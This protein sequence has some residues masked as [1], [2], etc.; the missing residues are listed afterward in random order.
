VSPSPS[1]LFWNELDQVTR[2]AY[3]FAG[4]VEHWY[5]VAGKFIVLRFA[6]TALLCLTYALEHLEIP[7]PAHDADFVIQVWDSKST[8]IAMIPAPWAMRESLGPRGT[9]TGYNDA[10]I[11]TSLNPESGLFSMVHLQENRAIVWVPG[12]EKLLA[13]EKGAPLL[14]VL[15]WWLQDHGLHLI[16]A[17]AVGNA[18]GHG[19]LL[20][21]QGGAGKSSTA[22]LCMVAGFTYLSDDYCIFQAQSSLVHSIYSTGKLLLEN[23]ALQPFLQRLMTQDSNEQKCVELGGKSLL[24]L[25]PEWK[26]KI[27][28]QLAI[29]AILLPCVTQAGQSTVVRVSP[30]IALQRLAMSSIFQLPLASSSLLSVLGTLV[31]SLPSYQL[32]LGQDIAQIPNLIQQ[33]LQ[34]HR[35]TLV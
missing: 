30:G 34:S 35:R 22:L 20:A 27:I 19:L 7:A 5:F 9:I 8:G 29:H 12:V 32:N 4:I 2:R 15:H 14:N 24:F 25:Y 28:Q 33:V 13:Y 17:A 23:S 26:T 11:R 6:G 1:L 16:H 10:V 18:Q 31:R 21:G 3:E